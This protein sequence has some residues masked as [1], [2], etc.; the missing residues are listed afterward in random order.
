M[1]TLL[2]GLAACGHPPTPVAV[3][4]PAQGDALAGGE[5]AQAP[6]QRAPLHE[7]QLVTLP[8][9]SPLITI[10]V[11]F[12]VG[13]A[14]DPAGKEGIAHVV[15]TLMADGGAGELTYSERVERLYPMAGS[16]DAHVGR[17]QTVFVG[18]VHADHL[19][20]FYALFRDTLLSPRFEQADFDRVMAQTQSALTLELRG[21]DDEVLGQEALQ[22]MIYADHPYGHPAIGTETGLASI[23]P[24]DVAAFRLRAFCAGRANV[25]V[26]GRLP[27]GFAA[28]V[29][30]DVR[31]LA[32]DECQGR[33]SLAAPATASGAPSVLLVSK[34]EA[35]AV[36]VSMGM[37]IDVTRADADYPALLLAASY[38]GQHRQFAGVLM[39]KIRGLRGMNY[40]DYAYAE[41]FTQEAWSRFPLTNISRRQQYF[42][43]WLR[44]LRREQAHFAIRL[45][46]RELRRFAQEGVSEEDFVRI[47]AFATRYYA[48]YQQTES[49][50]LGFA[51][52]DRFYGQDQAWLERLRTSWASLTR[53]ELNAAIRRHLHP[54][55]LQVAVVVPDAEAFATALA[56][57][58]ASPVEYQATVP[59]EV[60]AED[61]E[62]VSYPLGI[63]REAMHIV[64]MG[65]MFH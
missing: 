21:N 13:S 40:G 39:Q 51:L 42:S 36:A 19:E 20:D 63:P 50:R 4:P 31:S 27:E 60:I 1:L 54:E 9:T 24:E 65:Q 48:L 28:R 37:P 44:P 5:V 56:S 45:A 62:I 23:T 58:V 22:A 33:L 46:V 7:P 11:V 47:R 52:D 25:G 10:R 64:P 57:E 2:V 41:N 53:E 6:V 61:G 17:D 29:L 3:P 55:H 38:L 43:I 32:S 35:R 18:R 8:S 16:I 49:R 34:P 15:A 26:A 14:D 12:D 59:P 30:A